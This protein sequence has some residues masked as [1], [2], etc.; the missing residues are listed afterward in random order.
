M[1]TRQEIRAAAKRQR[2]AQRDKITV[3][4]ANSMTVIA[5]L[6]GLQEMPELTNAMLGILLVICHRQT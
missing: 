2:Q 6:F 4:C 3:L 5:Y 1:T